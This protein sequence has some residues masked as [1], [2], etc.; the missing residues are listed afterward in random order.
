MLRFVDF[1]AEENGQILGRGDE[2]HRLRDLLQF[3]RHAGPD[4]VPEDAAAARALVGD[5]QRLIEWH[6]DRGATFGALDAQGPDVSQ[7]EDETLF[8]SHRANSTP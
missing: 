8:C 2:P 1:D 6:A 5:P 4:V 3:R 7:V